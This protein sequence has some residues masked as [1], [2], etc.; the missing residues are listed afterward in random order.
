MRPRT[1]AAG[2]D[3]VTLR[4]RVLVWPHPGADRAWC[5]GD[6]S[7][8]GKRSWRSIGKLTVVLATQT[9]STWR[10]HHRV[11]PDAQLLARLKDRME[12][13]HGHDVGLPAPAATHDP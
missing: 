10:V 3:A 2:A 4:A 9:D 5:T 12:Q 8:R 1:T 7:G 6:A 13:A 11:T